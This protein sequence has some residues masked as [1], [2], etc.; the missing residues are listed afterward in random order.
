MKVLVHWPLLASL[1][2]AVCSFEHHQKTR[3]VGDQVIAIDIESDDRWQQVLQIMND[4]MPVREQDVWKA[5]TPARRSP[6]YIRVPLKYAPDMFRRLTADG[7]EFEIKIYDLEMAIAMTNMKNE[8]LKGRRLKSTDIVGTFPTYDEILAWI[9][10]IVETYPDLAST[11]SI[12]DTYEGRPMQVLRLGIPG[13]NKWSVWIDAAMHAREWIAPTTVIYIV[14]Q[15][16]QG[17][18]NSDPEITMFLEK[19][20]FHILPVAN[21][22]G[23]QYTHTTDRLWRKTRSPNGV[24]DCIGTD[25]N[26]NFAF[27][28]GGV[29]ADSDPCSNLFMGSSPQS[30]VETRNIVGYLL[31]RAESFIMYKSYHSWGQQFF[32]RWDYDGTVL[33]PDHEELLLL[34]WKAVYAINDVH[35]QVYEAGTAPTLMYPFAGSSS[36]WARGTANIKFSYLTE[37]RDADGDYAFV[38]PPSEIVP[39]GEEN[40]AGFQVLLRDIVDQYGVDLR[41]LPLEKP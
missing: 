23:Y 39:C 13:E 41:E 21:P 40:W 16:L 32:T 28:W 17:Y 38:P 9:A 8:R 15:L 11:F 12:G 26:R 6:G 4:F 29:N 30:E 22:D 7:F 34:A 20:D 25:L 35:G 31:P 14:D 1:V 10:D 36:D 2:V 18:A 37:L 24:T 33:P 5:P 19:L 27:Q 3:Y